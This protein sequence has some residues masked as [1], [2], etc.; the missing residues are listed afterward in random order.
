MDRKNTKI[1]GKKRYTLGGRS[2][3]RS[4]MRSR[5]IQGILVA[6]ATFQGLAVAATMGDTKVASVQVEAARAP[7]HAAV[8]LAPV[9][10]GAP[11][12][13][14]TTISDSAISDAWR[15]SAM[16]RES[17]R[18]AAKYKED[19]FKVTETLAAQIH[20]AA[21]ENGIDPEI[22]FGLVRAES[23]FRNQAT[24]PVGAVGLTQLMPATAR[25][26][27][28]GVTRSELRN[29]ETNLRVG[30]KYLKYLIEKYD[31]NEDLAL[32]AYNRGP[33]TV[34]KALKRGRNPD[35]GYAAFVRGKKNHGHKLYT[36]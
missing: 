25:W 17:D 26:M 24:S 19:G 29:P 2:D 11:K 27:E 33:G 3:L 21:V 32:V 6:T 7:L 15:E 18:L 9:T 36:R 16:E 14:E 13:T 30:F 5:T 4:L 8:A 34:D 20:E 12:A 28:P 10:A 23:S 22:A 1:I 35:N 31:G